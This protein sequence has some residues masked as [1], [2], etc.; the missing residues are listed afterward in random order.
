[1]FQRILTSWLYYRVCCFVLFF[2]AASASFSGFY[3]KWHFR[4][5]GVSESDEYASFESILDG[6]AYR[7]YVYRQL[8]PAAASLIGRMVPLS[9]Q[10]SWYSRSVEGSDAHIGGMADSSAARN[11]VYFLRYRVIY[12]AT[13]LF[14]LLA[15]YAMY[16]VCKA[17]EVPEPAAVFAP[18]IV[19]LLVPYIMSGGGYFYDYSE[20]AFLALAVWIALRFDWWWLIPVAALG[21]WNKESFLFIIPSLYPM[22]RRRH[23]RTGA[24][25]GVTVLCLVCGAIYYSLRL[26]FA[27]NPGSTVELSWHEQLQFFLSP[28]LL[29]FSLEKTYGMLVVS[30]FTVAPMALLVWT[31]WRA[32]GQLPRVIQQHAQIAAAI[33]IPL[34][35]LFSAPGELRDMSMLYIVFLMVLAVNLS[36][37]VSSSKKEETL[38]AG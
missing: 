37:W 38:Q 26:R 16:L 31:V 5:A 28:Q 13:F 10:N 32:W 7:P 36:N 1:M 33:N 27:Q 34:Y 30:V 17:L 21:A 29:L 9:I 8:L 4:E 22:F 20:L 14:A 15:V 24:W 3:D 6:T 23:S 35:L 18:V 12:L 25:L 19:I 2:V 11:K